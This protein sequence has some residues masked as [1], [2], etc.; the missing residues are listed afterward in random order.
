MDLAEPTASADLERTF[1]YQAT[2]HQHHLILIDI[3]TDIKMAA[4]GKI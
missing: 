3:Q 2:D 4:N 1:S